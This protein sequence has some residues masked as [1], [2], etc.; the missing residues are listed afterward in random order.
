MGGKYKILVT[1][2]WV[3][4]T[5][6]FSHEIGE[7]DTADQLDLINM[8]V[9]QFNMEAIN[10]QDIDDLELMLNKLAIK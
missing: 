5:Q 9:Q 10:E 7:H 8:K 6:R 1:V 4:P 2:Q 3:S